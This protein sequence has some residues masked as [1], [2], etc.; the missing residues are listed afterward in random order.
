MLP[1]AVSQESPAPDQAACVTSSRIC[2]VGEVGEA[3]LSH[4]P[5]HVPY[6]TCCLSEFV[7]VRVVRSQAVLGA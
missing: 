6:L 5:P 3:H 2:G 4:L 1:L 7:C